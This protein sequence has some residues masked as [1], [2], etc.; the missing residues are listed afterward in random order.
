MSNI[1][2]GLGDVFDEHVKCEFEDKDVD[3]TMK[4]RVKE[5]YDLMMASTIFLLLTVNPCIPHFKQRTKW[6]ISL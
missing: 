5:P 3:A 6:V 4:T 2:E 1:S